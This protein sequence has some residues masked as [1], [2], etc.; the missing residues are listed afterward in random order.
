M[1]NSSSFF[2]VQVDVYTRWLFQ[3]YPISDGPQ[4]VHEDTITFH[5][6]F[7]VYFFLQL[8]LLSSKNTDYQNCRWI[9]PH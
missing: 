2:Q 4:I 9:L 5:L 8:S 7:P 1:L 3:H 6:V